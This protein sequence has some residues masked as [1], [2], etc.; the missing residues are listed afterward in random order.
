MNPNVY[1]IFLFF[2]FYLFVCENPQWATWWSYVEIEYAFD[3]FNSELKVLD[4]KAE[5]GFVK[6]PEKKETKLWSTAVVN[7]SAI[8]KKFR[9]NFFHKMFLSGR[10]V[11]GLRLIAL[12]L[13]VL[14]I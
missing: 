13:L 7:G 11:S 2:Y 6:R 5:D 14:G 4:M 3:E 8:S 9:R 1:F 12:V 10:T